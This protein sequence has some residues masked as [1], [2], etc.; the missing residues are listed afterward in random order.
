MTTS[1][2]ELAERAAKEFKEK[3]G[4]ELG[5]AKVRSMTR[6]IEKKSPD[7]KSM[8]KWK[9][10]FDNE[11]K[12]NAFI[13]WVR[14][15]VATQAV[16]PI[17]D[18]LKKQTASSDSEEQ[19]KAPATSPVPETHK[20]PATSR[21]PDTPEKAPE[22]ESKSLFNFGAASFVPNIFASSTPF[23][24]DAKPFTQSKAPEEPS[25]EEGLYCTDILCPKRHPQ[26]RFTDMRV[27]TE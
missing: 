27:P 13:Q 14:E 9:S 17:P 3:T 19:E 1:A 25:C 15:L 12:L 23:N 11:D 22:A 6:F 10:M 2:R 8:G 4:I 5:D 20:A 18:V 21:T 26:S 16:P 24:A 7:L